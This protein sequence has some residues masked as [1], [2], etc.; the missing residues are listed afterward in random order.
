MRLYVS[1]GAGLWNGFPVRLGVPS[2]IVRC[3]L[4]SAV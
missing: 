2:E 3:V 1:S 4:R